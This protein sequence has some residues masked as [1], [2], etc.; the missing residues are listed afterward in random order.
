MCSEF[1]FGV[2][3]FVMLLNWRP[4]LKCQKQLLMSSISNL[5]GCESLEIAV[6]YKSP[7]IGLQADST[8]KD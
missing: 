6:K 5:G 7:I 2:F 3:L 8:E 4:H 1:E